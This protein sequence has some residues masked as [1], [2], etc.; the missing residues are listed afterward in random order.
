MD[1]TNAVPFIVE[2]EGRPFVMTKSCTGDTEYV[3]YLEDT[4]TMRK[5]YKAEVERYGDTVYHV[6][7]VNGEKMYFDYSDYLYTHA[8]KG[9][10]LL[11]VFVALVAGLGFGVYSS[12]QFFS[13]LM[14]GI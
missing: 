3:E 9:K 1:Y 13:I 8:G 12:V 11:G 14:N 5:T 7:Q 6:V 4:E 10:L 2:I